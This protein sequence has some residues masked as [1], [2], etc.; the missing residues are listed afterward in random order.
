MENLRIYDIYD[1]VDDG[2][3]E[4]IYTMLNRYHPYMNKD[5]SL[6]NMINHITDV[7]QNEAQTK[8]AKIQYE[9]YFAELA[10]CLIENTNPYGVDFLEFIIIHILKFGAILG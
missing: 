8:S 4:S 5:F 3:N 6:A 9:K 1:F 7:K 10:D 2:V